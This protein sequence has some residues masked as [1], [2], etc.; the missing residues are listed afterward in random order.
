MLVPRD[1]QGQGP[2]G[3]AESG[4]CEPLLTLT[5]TDQSVNLVYMHSCLKTYLLYMY[6]GLALNSF[7]SPE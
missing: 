3:S 4:P 2:Q 5:S 7:C 1:L 6:P